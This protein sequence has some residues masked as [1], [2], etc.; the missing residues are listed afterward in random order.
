MKEDIMQ[1]VRIGLDLAKYVGAMLI[2]SGRR[3]RAPRVMFSCSSILREANSRFSILRPFQVL[4]RVDILVESHDA[5]VP[6]CT[7]ALITRVSA[8]HHIQRYHARAR[9]LSDFPGGFLP[10]LTRLAPQAVLAGMDERRSGIQEWLYLIARERGFG[11]ARRAASAAGP[12][13]LTDMCYMD[14]ARLQQVGWI[15]IG[16]HNC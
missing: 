12:P 16:G 5:V 8:T 1:V 4:R 10:G 6:G 11:G 3:S 7:E 2:I 14:P 9:L 15:R 13:C